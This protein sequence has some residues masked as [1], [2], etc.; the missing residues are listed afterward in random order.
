MIDKQK[1]VIG[2]ISEKG[3][4]AKSSLLVAIVKLIN[5]QKK[6]M[7]IN[8]DESSY[9]VYHLLKDAKLMNVSYHDYDWQ[10]LPK[11]LSTGIV[12]FPYVFI[13][14]KGEQINQ[15]Q[16]D[17]IKDYVDYFILP[18]VP[19]KSNLGAFDHSLSMFNQIDNSKVIAIFCL[20]NNIKIDDTITNEFAK[21]LDAYGNIICHTAPI[22]TVKNLEVESKTILNNRK[23]KSSLNELLIN[24]KIKT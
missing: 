19:S 18:I 5:K 7:I 21:K 17:S 3:G 11:L 23:N 20:L 2:F 15:E 6:S 4:V 1:V 8:M 13:D 10:G 16:L 24:L 22:Y 14:F 12:K 9:S